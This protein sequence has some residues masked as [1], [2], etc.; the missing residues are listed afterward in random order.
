MAWIG[1]LI[2][3]GASLIGGMMS[4]RGSSNA[5]AMNMAIWRDQRNWMERMSNTEAQRRVQDLKNAGLNPMLAQMQGAASTPTSAMPRMENEM[6]GM[7]AA[8]SSAGQAIAQLPVLMQAQAQTRK[9]NAEASIIEKQIPYSAETAKMNLESLKTGFDKLT[10]EMQTA[11]TSRDLKDVELEELQPLLIALSKLHVQ[12]E[13]LGM[14]G[15]KAENEFWSKL[16]E[17]KW[18]RELALIFKALK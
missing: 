3:A 2:G 12:A 1:P 13:E 7:G 9:T 18:I 14:A 8:M 17:A 6:A 16:P 5:N 4:N 11:K 10:Y 15:K